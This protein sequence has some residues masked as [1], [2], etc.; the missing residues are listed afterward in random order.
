MSTSLRKIVGG[1]SAVLLL[2]MF[3]VE[4]PAQNKSRMQDASRHASEQHASR[5]LAKP[6]GRKVRGDE[7]SAS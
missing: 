7:G 3:A 1:V 5:N 6:N 4:S 2:V